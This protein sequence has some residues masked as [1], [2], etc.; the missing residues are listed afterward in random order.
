MTCKWIYMLL[1]ARFVS[2]SCCLILSLCEPLKGSPYGCLGLWGM[3]GFSCCF[4]PFG[5]GD[6]VIPPF[7]HYVIVWQSNGL[8]MNDRCTFLL[9]T[10]RYMVIESNKMRWLK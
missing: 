5:L 7:Y 2:R 8:I 6:I 3:L 10:I 9:K 4:G 1:P